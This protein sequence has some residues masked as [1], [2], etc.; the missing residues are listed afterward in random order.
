M[1]HFYFLQNII[2]EKHQLIL[3]YDWYD[4]N[5]KVKKS[6]IG[7][8][9]TNLTLADIKF[10]TIGIGYTYYFSPQAKIIF[11]VDLVTNETTNLAGYTTDQKDD[12]FTC[13]FQFRF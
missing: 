2:N 3:K 11:Y 10:S 7:K 4:P 9:G 5:T 1:A 6:E 12:V 13:R 8:A